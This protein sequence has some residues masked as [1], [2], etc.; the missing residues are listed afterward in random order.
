MRFSGTSSAV[1]TAC[2]ALA[3][4]TGSAGAA[5]RPGPELL[6]APPAVAPQLTNAG[7]W[8]AQPILVSGTT[9]Y[10]QGEFL[11]QDYLYDDN[12]AQET[13]D[14][15]DPRMNG[16]LFSKQNGTY[17]YPTDP[18]YAG[19]AADIVE[20]RLKPL[21]GA[22]AFRLTL[23]TLKDQ[24]LVAFTIALARV[25]APSR[26]LPFGA[27]V[28][29]PADVVVTV[30]PL[31]GPGMMGSG[32]AGGL[33][34][35]VTD[36]ATGKT[37]GTATVKVDDRRRQVEVR[38]PHAL[39]DPR[40]GTRRVALGVGLWD[41]SAGKYLLPQGG[42]DATHPGGGGP[43]GGPAA[44]FN[45]AFRTHE[46]VPSPTEGTAVETS[47][48]WWR[49]RRQGIELAKGDISRF[50]ID[51]NFGKLARRVTDDHAVPRTGPM[52]RILASRFEP[53]QGTDFSV[54][55]F[56]S[57]NLDCT[58]SYVGR[59]QPY[60]IYIP[61]KPMQKPGYGLT[62]LLHS[63]S[64]MYNQYLGTR[65]QSQYGERGGGN[66]V[67]TP[68]GRGPDGF[69]ESYGAA[70]VFEVM[71]DVMRRYKIDRSR[72]VTT[73]YSMG[74]IGSL[75]LASQ[76]P[77]LFARLHSTVG[78]EQNTDVLASL[79]NVPVLMWNTH[80]D[81][82][83]NEA[84]FTQTA[85]ALD[86]LGYR[87]ELDVFQPCANAQCSPL[88]PNH[89]ELAVNDQFAP[90]AAFLDDAA[91]DRNPQRVTYV[92]DGARNKP[93][94]EMVGD[95]AYWVSG[96]TLR[97][98]SK[99]GPGGEPIGQIDAVSHALGTLEPASVQ[100]PP[101]NGNLSGGNLGP[102]VYNRVG[103]TWSATESAPADALKITA[104]NIATATIDPKRAKLTCAAKV[105]ITSDGPI[106]VTL[107]GCDKTIKGG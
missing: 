100:L 70:D 95:H 28:S 46:D 3:I 57:N 96:L 94:L 79:R 8:H 92:V 75:R 12:G 17:T 99:N 14:P 15:G 19:N 20:L 68:E 21:K 44:F 32:V 81:E 9:A 93:A 103:R 39:W 41:A 64:A 62:L 47:P 23:N 87:Y 107:A 16:N 50:S 27:N 33:V 84:F 2:S 40:R 74:G 34:G 60:A 102:L 72:T 71:A 48:A 91:V 1:L 85:Q 37:L 67:V 31:S 11:Y 65:N 73:G 6:Y 101:G 55:C 89:L 104:T 82:L 80:G 49:D 56:P 25:D 45:V 63:L 76:F 4:L 53:K 66:I 52:D 30:H 98:P 61:R 29:A 86:A 38:L 54:A 18:K 42:A 10:R 88:F 78:F 26:P 59:L 36:G 43:A 51:V 97:D 105:D 22:T 35:T 90:G 5:V 77:D 13:V 106:T 83:A 58:G 24:S 7:I 69:Y